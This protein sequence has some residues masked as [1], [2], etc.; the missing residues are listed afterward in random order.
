MAHTLS[1][2]R[3]D[4]SRRL[5]QFGSVLHTTASTSPAEG[6]C[7]MNSPVTHGSAIVLP[8]RAVVMC[9]SRT[10][11]WPVESRDVRLLSLL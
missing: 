1:V 11:L 6:D 4:S 5:V 3:R 7:Y 10:T 8:R 2:P 9:F